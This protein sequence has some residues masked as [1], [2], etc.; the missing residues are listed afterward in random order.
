LTD[1]ST[2]SL[3]AALPI[4]SFTSGDINHEHQGAA[5]RNVTQ[6]FMA[7][8]EP[9]MRSFDQTGNIRNGGPPVTWQLHHADDRMKRRERIC[10][11]LDRKSTRL[12]SSH[13]GIS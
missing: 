13:L 7:Q 9:P 3:H 8:P 4:S 5:A 11:N 2:L 10:R 12:N 6:E 1:T